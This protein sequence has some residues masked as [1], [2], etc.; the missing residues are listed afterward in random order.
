[1]TFNFNNSV[2]SI[3]VVNISQDGISKGEVHQRDPNKKME[4]EKG[5][6]ATK[7][8]KQGI[9]KNLSL[10]GRLALIASSNGSWVLRLLLSL[11][12]ICASIMLV[13]II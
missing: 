7:K 13:T 1:M 3:S 10:S 11:S 2:D 5:T 6:T 12:I 8:K 4:M 9:R